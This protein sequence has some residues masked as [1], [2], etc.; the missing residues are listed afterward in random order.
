MSNLLLQTIR[1]SRLVSVGMDQLL[2]AEFHSVGDFSCMKSDE[3]HV[4]RT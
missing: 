3:L 4:Q 1:S 2:S